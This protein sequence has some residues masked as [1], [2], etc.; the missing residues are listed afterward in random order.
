MWY[1]RIWV[2]GG[3]WGAMADAT[4]VRHRDPRA[5]RTAIH[6]IHGAR[7]RCAGCGGAGWREAEVRGWSVDQGIGCAGTMWIPC[8]SHV[9]P[10]AMCGIRCFGVR[11]FELWNACWDFETLRT[12][13]NCIYIIYDL[14]YCRM[15]DP[16]NFLT[17][18]D[19]WCHRARLLNL[20]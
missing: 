14:I 7:A 16:L 9:D 4:A 11:K 2:Q 15:D 1:V 8:G 18:P 5:T 10:S 17:N 19:L 20:Q 13:Y 12:I 6:G 3:C